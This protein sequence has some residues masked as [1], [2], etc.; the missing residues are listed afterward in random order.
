MENP[1]RLVIGIATHD[2]PTILAETIAFLAKQT[3]QPDKIL[4]AYAKPADVASAP[5][6]FPHV[7]FI[8]TELGLTRQRNAILTMA[9]DH[10]ILLFIDDDFYLDPQYLKITERFFVENPEVVVS[11]GTVLAD[12]IR[13][14]GLTVA[15]AKSIVAGSN[16][17][18]S[19][20][21]ITPIF[22]AYGCNMCLRL[23]P[24]REYGLCFDETLPLYG[25][26]EDWDF[27]R[28]I[29][30]YGS[31]VHISNASGVHL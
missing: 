8:Q 19:E 23:A 20:Q 25:R 9:R 28:R 27:S 24:I 16:H 1:T 4:V 13:G 12:D 15:Q 22:F 21:R 11:T 17:A 2:R 29:T 31:L 26:Y 10:D 18:Q 7:T 14:P 30:P 6:L 3:R 5:S